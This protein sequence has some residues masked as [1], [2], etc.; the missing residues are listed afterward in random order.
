MTLRWRRRERAP[1][2][3][4]P[5]VRSPPPA[6]PPPVLEHEE[7]WVGAVA[8]PYPSGVHRTRHL[9]RRRYRGDEVCRSRSMSCATSRATSA[10]CRPRANTRGTDGSL[11]G[12]DRPL[13][14]VTD[15]IEPEALDDAKV[16][17]G[18]APA[19][20]TARTI[21]IPAPR[22]SPATWNGSRASAACG[23][24]ARHGALRWRWIRPGARCR[25]EGFGYDG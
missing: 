22:W 6:F 17:V 3:C 24:G 4:S 14:L 13:Q 15:A 1:R 11:V 21:R 8:L 5:S 12:G 20:A 7:K 25:N 16:E 23:G 2:R 18:S 9:R 19:S 10:R